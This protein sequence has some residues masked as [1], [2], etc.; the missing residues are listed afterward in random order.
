MKKFGKKDDL[1]KGTFENPI[2]LPLFTYPSPLKNTY[3]INILHAEK[4]QVAEGVGFEP[5]VQS[6]ARRFS[7]PVP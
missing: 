6:P 1:D 5:T 7:R 4:N 2:P 3:K